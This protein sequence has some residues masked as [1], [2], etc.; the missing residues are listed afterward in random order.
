MYNESHVPTFS[1]LVHG[2]HI[3]FTQQNLLSTVLSAARHTE[4]Y[5]AVPT[6]KKLIMGKGVKMSRY[7]YTWPTFIVTCGSHMWLSSAKMGE[8][9]LQVESRKADPEPGR[10]V[11]PWSQR[12]RGSC[13]FLPRSPAPAPQRHLQPRT[14]ESRPRHWRGDQLCSRPSCPA[15][16]LCVLECI[17]LMQ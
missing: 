14:G 8:N 7:K 10:S 12:W 2:T 16:S 11:K 1:V 9:A 4:M 13:A 3:N 17:K 6:L 15:T 5:K